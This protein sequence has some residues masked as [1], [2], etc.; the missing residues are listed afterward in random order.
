M[1]ETVI[2]IR[3]TPRSSGN[4]V[5][6]LKDGVFRVKVTAPPVEGKANQALI[7]FLSKALGIPKG[8]LEIVSGVKSRDKTIRIRGMTGQEAKKA[9]TPVP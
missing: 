2:R 3:L 5:S 1:E 4:A 7:A 8:R 6:G 9:L